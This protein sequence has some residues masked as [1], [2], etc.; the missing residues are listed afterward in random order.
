M[1]VISIALLV[2]G[3]VLAIFGVQSMNSTSSSVSRFFNGTPTDKTMEMLIAGIVAIV[4]G[5]AG[6]VLPRRG[7]K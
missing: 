5:V 1:K 4:L 7:L 3:I 2:S 6:I